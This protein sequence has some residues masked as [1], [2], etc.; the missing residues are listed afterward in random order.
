MAQRAKTMLIDGSNT[1]HSL[2]ESWP[3][4]HEEQNR[5]AVDFIVHL[6]SW[7][8]KQTDMEVE[9]VFDGGF[10][11]LQGSAHSDSVRILF[12]DYASADSVILERL[13]ALRYFKRKVTVVTWDRELAQDAKKEDAKIISPERLWDSIRRET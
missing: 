6:S 11:A 5:H 4:S 3:D 10:R 9:I 13:R 8:S 1:V 2:Y 12:S 7:A